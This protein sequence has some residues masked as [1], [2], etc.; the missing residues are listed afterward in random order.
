M[1]NVGSSTKFLDM[2]QELIAAGKKIP[3]NLREEAASAG[4]KR[5]VERIDAHNAGEELAPLVKAERTKAEPPTPPTATTIGTDANEKNV[6]A[7][8]D[9]RKKG[10]DKALS[11]ELA[12]RRKAEGLEPETA[13]A[14]ETPKKVK[15]LTEKGGAPVKTTPTTEA[16]KPLVIRRKGEK[17]S[18]PEAAPTP[19]VK[20]SSPTPELDKKI[21]DIENRLPDVMDPK[22]IAKL[23][24]ERNAL[25]EQRKSAKPASPIETTTPEAPKTEAMSLEN[26]KKTTAPEVTT[27]AP[28]V[29][30]KVETPAAPTESAVPVILDTKTNKPIA[31]EEAKALQQEYTQAVKEGTVEQFKQNKLKPLGYTLL[32]LGGLGTA[33]KNL[34]PEPTTSTT[35][36]QVTPP[37]P[38]PAP[39]PAK[40]TTPAEP[41]T[42]QAPQAPEAPQA[43][44][45]K[46]AKAF[47]AGSPEEVA[48]YFKKIQEV[49]SPMSQLDEASRTR[50]EGLEST[51][52]SRIAEAKTIYEQTVEKARTDADRREAILTWASI[53]EQLGQAI[54][55]YFAA[56]E[57]KRLG[58]RIG[59]ELKFQKHDWAG[60]LDRSLKKMESQLSGAKEKYG[61]V[62][63]EV[64]AGREA[65]GKER[66]RLEDRAAK[67]ADTFIRAALDERE[68]R[69]VEQSR[70]AMKAEDRA[71]EQA[72]N[73]AKL[74]NAVRVQEMRLEQARAALQTKFSE[75]QRKEADAVKNARSE[76]AGIFNSWYAAKGAKKGQEGDKFAKAAKNLQLTTQ[77]A[78]ELGRLAGRPGFFNEEENKA[79]A[80]AILQQAEIRRLNNMSG[81]QVNVTGAEEGE[82]PAAQTSG[83]EPT[84]SVIFE[85]YEN[86]PRT[87]TEAQ[88]KAA[89]AKY[90]ARVKK[91]GAQ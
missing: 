15:E 78:Q 7:L 29:A 41:T 83:Q 3:A 4:F 57:G 46:K 22:Q 52:N 8:E 39:A 40:P 25:L 47:A 18:A 42:P 58:A 12:K 69:Q 90:G 61:I 45:A 9:L 35:T 51:L 33:A 70:A 34:A 32:A 6:Q 53:G 1:A 88:F 14:P 21:E 43:A 20:V 23:N 49:A 28:S 13:P 5:T 63:K 87:M 79:A 82:A 11:E 80:A 2:I 56:R 54:T 30:A 76:A 59:S 75:A 68:R 67:Q 65:L 64:E 50:L 36:N 72:Q 37:T 10:G 26:I 16:S 86:D 66:T 38:A 44:P 27:P 81:G 17:P 48:D 60:D 62:S 71:F 55:Q 19:E 89:Q 77:E 85:G 31:A 84:F 73:A 24:K 74:N 91:V